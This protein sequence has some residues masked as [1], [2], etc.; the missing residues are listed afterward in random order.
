M[1]RQSLNL[2]DIVPTKFDD[3]VIPLVQPQLTISS[4]K[5]TTTGF[6]SRFSAAISRANARIAVALKQALDEAISSPIWPTANDGNEDIVD[7]GALMES[8]KVTVT[9]NGV[10]IVYDSDYALFVSTGGFIN[11]YGNI[12]V[13]VYLPPRP[14]VEATVLGGYGLPP[15]NFT[16]FYEEELGKEFR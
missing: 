13:R 6:E 16:A 15:F 9:N 11:P 5:V 1:S 14:W 8:G 12:S 10:Q 3:I 2:K 4:V 7:T